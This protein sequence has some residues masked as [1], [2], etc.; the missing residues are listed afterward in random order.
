MCCYVFNCV[1]ET[2]GNYWMHSFY[3]VC[4]MGMMLAGILDSIT[5]FTTNFT[6]MQFH[7]IS[8]SIYYSPTWFSLINNLKICLY[9][10]I[11]NVSQRQ[12]KH[13]R[14]NVEGKVEKS[15]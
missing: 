3:C 13:L 8:M 12:Q 11:K 5:I 1:L 9:M 14:Y 4:F 7:C 10:F 2:R 6:H 15:F